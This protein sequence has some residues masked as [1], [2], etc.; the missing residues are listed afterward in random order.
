MKAYVYDKRNPGN[1]LAMREVERPE[2]KD[3]EVLVEIRAVSVNAA[4]Y[5]SMKMGLIPKSGIFGA[6]ISGR[7]AKVGS[8][9]TSFHA[10][11]EVVC[12]SSGC[13]FGGF[14]E[15][16]ALPESALTRKPGELTH[17]TCAA[18]PMAA[19]TARQG[20]VKAGSPGSGAKVLINGASGGVGSFAVQ[21]ASR[22]GAEVTGVC[23]TANADRVKLL[24]AARIIDYRTAS[25]ADLGARYD[26]IL[27]IH[28]N[29]SLR[30]YRSLLAEGGTYVMIGGEI[31]HIFR[32]I[33]LGP[34]FSLGKANMRALAARP[35]PA[36]LEYVLGLISRG[37]IK[38]DIENV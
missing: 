3:R 10:G 17:E 7:I 29:Y 28:G 37:D 20:L 38:P 8:A 4:D 13:G 9:V 6:D 11:D 1:P 24:G 36:D 31:S 33:L 12:D 34:L 18:V 26:A 16:V 2:P 32:S 5:R 19:V 15:Y 22:A 27:A 14:A 30:L 35:S 25:L 23:G 21:L